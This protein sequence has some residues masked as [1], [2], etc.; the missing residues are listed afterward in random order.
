MNVSW[1]WP[2]T[3]SLKPS[4]QNARTHSKKQIRQ[5]IGRMLRPGKCTH[6][7]LADEHGNAIAGH[8]R[9]MAAVDLDLK[10]VPVF[11]IAGLTALDID[12][13][14]HPYGRGTMC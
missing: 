1:N 6:P 10:T 12:L 14:R 7:R 5:I 9:L 8:A 2:S 4:K 3:P 13:V 11:V